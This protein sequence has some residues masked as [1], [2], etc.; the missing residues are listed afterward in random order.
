MAFYPAGPNPHYLYV[1]NTNSVIRF[2][3]RNGDTRARSAPEKVVP[4]L[5]A[6]GKLKGGG[7][8]TR[9]LAFSRDGAKMYVSVGSFTNV[10]EEREVNEAGRA[11]IHEYNP[12]GTGHR[13]YATGIRNPVGLAIHPQTGE[14]WTAVNER[15]G[16]GDHLP[17]DYVTR[18]QEGGFYGWPWY[19]LGQNQDP[20]HPGEEPQL[21]TKTLTPEVLL[22]AHSAALNLTFYTGSQF[23]AE[24][25]NDAFLALHGS[26]NRARRTGYKLV[27][28][29]LQDGKP[30]GEYED[31]MT[32]F[33]TPDANVWGRPVGV[34]VN[35]EGVLLVTDD[36]GGC[37]WRITYTGKT[38]PR[39][40]S[41]KGL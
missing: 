3:Y 10:W 4:I 7:H 21:R 8:W 1:A 27:R 28:L 33:V 6:G 34:T 39:Y 25:R 32:G 12:D 9:N 41:N 23:P 2:S 13:F 22:Q 17:F 26:W 29:R 11:A 35:K 16:L 31:F 18:V 30:T 38:Q 5:P 40:P 24:Y 37:V 15:D 36:A 20:R 14:L 19:Y